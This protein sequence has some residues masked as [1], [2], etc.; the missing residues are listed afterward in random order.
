MALGARHETT[1]VTSGTSGRYRRLRV[2]NIAVGVFP[3]TGA[4]FSAS[5]VLVLIGPFVG[6]RDLAAVLALFLRT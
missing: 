6:L 2:L 1:G 3:A 4:A 5:L